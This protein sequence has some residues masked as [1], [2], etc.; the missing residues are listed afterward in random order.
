MVR[1]LC[2]EWESGHS[3]ARWRRTN[4]TYR[5]SRS[6]INKSITIRAD[7]IIVLY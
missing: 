7:I 6:S 4:E 3:L 2:V 5:D 1:G